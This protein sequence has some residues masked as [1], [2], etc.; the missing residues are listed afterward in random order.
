MMSPLRNS[1]EDIDVIAVNPKKFHNP[2]REAKESIVHV[3]VQFTSEKLAAAHINSVDAMIYKSYYVHSPQVDEHQVFYPNDNYRHE[4]HVWP[5][6]QCSSRAHTTLDAPTFSLDPTA[7][8]QSPPQLEEVAPNGQSWL[9][10]GIADAVKETNIIEEEDVDV[11]KEASPVEELQWGANGW[12][13]AQKE[14]A[15]EGGARVCVQPDVRRDSAVAA[16][17]AEIPPFTGGRGQVQASSSP[18]EGGR[19]VP[20][21]P[22]VQ[23]NSRLNRWTS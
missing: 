7:D 17:S 1:L 16:A 3:Y 11:E 15:E 13:L 10:S 2:V 5:N 18:S 20:E 21:I 14:A 12:V 6:P 4:D 9:F 22:S 23:S 19:V 8:D